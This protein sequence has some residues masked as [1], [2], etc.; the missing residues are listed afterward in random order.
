MAPASN[1]EKLT[2]ALPRRAA[3]PGAIRIIFAKSILDIGVGCP[4][5]KLLRVPAGLLRAPAN[6]SI[7]G[8]HRMRREAM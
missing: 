1:L 2:G 5:C 3:E 8:M 6:L 7:K 4:D